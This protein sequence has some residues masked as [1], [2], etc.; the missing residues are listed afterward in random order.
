M[1]IY[2]IHLKDMEILDKTVLYEHYLSEVGKLANKIPKE[3]ARVGIMDLN[4]LIQECYV[5][6]I[7]G[8]EDLDW[9]WIEGLDTEDREAAI[10]G[11]LKRRIISKVKREINNKRKGI[12][13][14][15]YLLDQESSAQVYEVLFP[16]FFKDEF[17]KAAAESAISMWDIEQ[18]A[19]GL[20][21]LMNETL[22]FKERDI[23]NR[24]YGIDQERESQAKIAIFYKTSASYIGVTKARAIKKMQE[25]PDAKKII[26]KYFK[27]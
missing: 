11:Y 1:K 7:G 10:W 15:E 2:S 27:I 19:I 17:Q 3:Y 14:P 9:E 23:L 22:N 18:L 25:Y 26:R 5:A 20:E 8:W 13:I 12:R 16:D 4:D 6:F 24:F 21:V